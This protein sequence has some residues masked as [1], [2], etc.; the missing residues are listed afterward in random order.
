MLDIFVCITSETERED[1]LKIVEKT[2][3]VKNLD[4]KITK[5][6]GN[7]YDILEMVKKRKEP[8]IYFLNVFFETD[9]N[10]IQ[11]GAKLREY[12]ELGVI[13]YITQ[14]IEL[15][16]L[17]Y[18]YKVEAL[19]YILKND[20]KNL[21]ERVESCL[22]RADKKLGFDNVEMKKIKVKQGDIVFSISIDD[23]FYF[24]TSEKPHR[25][26]LHKKEEKLEFVGNLKSLEISIGTDFFRCHKSYLIN[27][28][29]VKEI[30]I[31]EKTVLMDNNEVCLVSKR[32]IND[33]IEEI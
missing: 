10:G 21:E 16:Y 14:H 22:E 8:A 31:K 1:F 11:L 6:T 17:S 26:I 32:F 28:S 3:F 23:I 24:E 13:V 12:D 15:L 29:K 25:I 30:N 19:D 2:I 9:I 27:K 33:L 5:L 4:M 7:P 20:V 18:I